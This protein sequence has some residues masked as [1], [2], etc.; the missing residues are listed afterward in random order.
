MKTAT[1]W[2]LGIVIGLIII[3]AV[4]VI[5]FL[6]FNRFG[7][8]QWMMESRSV[9]PFDGYRNLPMHP[10]MVPYQGIFSF[11]PLAFIGGLIFY[12]A[13]AFLVVLGIISL[14]RVAIR[15]SKTT[16]VTPQVSTPVAEE[17]KMN[18]CPS[19]GHI[20]QPE[21]HHCAYCGKELA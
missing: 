16:Q 9:R 8:V 14:V 6:V 4:V 15:P 19:C 1:K 3:T 20:I 10:R 17:I 5:G 18:S 11:S 13:L 12:A 21:W 7:G 2:I